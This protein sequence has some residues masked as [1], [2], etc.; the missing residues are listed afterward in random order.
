MRHFYRT[1]CRPV[2]VMEAADRFFTKLG[3]QQSS[4]APRSRVFSGIVGTPE[5]PATLRLTVR[6]EG[7]HYT[8]VEI[9]TDQIGESRLDR[10]V[11]RFFVE[12]HRSDDPHHALEAAY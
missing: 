4:S 6:A 11:K 10:N 5:V 12:L 3:L 9:E 2:D 1:Q 7:G 8:F